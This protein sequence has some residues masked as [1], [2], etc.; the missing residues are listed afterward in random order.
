MFSK[1]EGDYVRDPKGGAIGEFHMERAK[2]AG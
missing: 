1:D 2:K